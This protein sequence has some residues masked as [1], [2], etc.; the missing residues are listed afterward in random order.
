MTIAT[1]DAEVMCFGRW[2]QTDREGNFTFPEQRPYYYT[3][4]VE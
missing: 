4:P 1:P 2:M 3:F